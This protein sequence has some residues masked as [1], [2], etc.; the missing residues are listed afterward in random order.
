MHRKENNIKMGLK[1]T[2]YKGK[3]KNVK[4]SLSLID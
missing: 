4:F 1:A 3:D 2:E